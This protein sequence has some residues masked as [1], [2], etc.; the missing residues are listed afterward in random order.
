M[1][2]L[3]TRFGSASANADGRVVIRDAKNRLCRTGKVVRRVTDLVV[4]HDRATSS[5]RHRPDLTG[6]L[7][8]VRETAQRVVE[9][10]R[11]FEISRG[12]TCTAPGLAQECCRQSPS[13][14]AVTGSALP[15]NDECG[16]GNLR[17]LRNIG[18]GQR[19][20]VPTLRVHGGNPCL[21]T[22]HHGMLR[23][24][25]SFGEPARR[26][27]IQPAPSSQPHPFTDHRTRVPAVRRADLRSAVA[28]G[29]AVHARCGI[30]LPA[31]GR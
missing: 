23:G 5:A 11:R 24:D 15:G 3:K 14:T 27:P 25:E 22:L 2:V 13:A 18:T 6:G 8:V 21:R 31:T 20:A 10:L 9:G 16:H 29:N 26:R 12:A 30:Q 4:D 1:A 19:I 28:H 17:K 7:H